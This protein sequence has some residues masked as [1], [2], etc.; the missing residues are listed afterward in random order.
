MKNQRKRGSYL[1]ALGMIAVLILLAPLA[2]QALAAEEQSTWV[3]TKERPQPS[4]W[5]WGPKFE[6]NKP[7][8]GGYLRT[9]APNY[10]GLMNP[11]HWPVNDWVAM[12]YMYEM[13]IYNDG[14]FKPTVR[15][16]AESWEYPDPLTC[17]MKLRKG[18]K[19]HDG[20]DFNAEGFAGGKKNP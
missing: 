15:W 14:E 13:M 7:V 8:R 16:L 6:P 18:V 20:S 1:F 10:I 4:W 9:A 19:F 2:G 5:D 3:W 11:N 17:I 12:T